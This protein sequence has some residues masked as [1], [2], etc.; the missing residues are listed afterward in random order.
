MQQPFNPNDLAG[1]MGWV[2]V[3]IGVVLAV[4]LTIAI[5]YLLTLR[6]DAT[7]VAE[8]ATEVLAFGTAV[9]LKVPEAVLV[10]T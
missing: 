6:Y 8:S 5:F 9:K 4:A 2:C 10:K 7:S 3:I 1:I